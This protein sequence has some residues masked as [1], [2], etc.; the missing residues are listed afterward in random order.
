MTLSAEPLRGHD[1]IAAA[2]TETVGAAKVV[3][4]HTHLFAPAFGPL[5]LWGIDELLNY[6]YLIAELFRVAPIRYG[7]WWEMPREEQADMIWSELFVKRPPI[8]EATQ[9]VVRVMTAFGLDATAPDLREARAFF[10]A[11]DAAAHAERVLD[12]AG[13]DWLVMTNDPFDGEEAALWRAGVTGT[14]RYRAALRLDRMLNAW[15]EACELLQAGGYAVTEDVTGDTF[16]EGRR[17]LDDWI[18][19]MKPLYMAVSLPSDFVFP[20]DSARTRLLRGVVL[21]TCLEH[22]LPL[23][24]MIGVRRQVNPNMRLAGDAVGRADITSV[25]HIAFEYPQVRYLITM[26][27]R[28]NQHEL[29]VSA[30]KFRNL[31]PFGCWWFL[32]NPSIVREITQERLE[33]LGATFIAQHSDARVLDQLLYKWPVSRTIIARALTETYV[34]LADAGRPVTGAD[35][36]SDVDRLF[37]QNFCAWVGA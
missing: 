29:C 13:V 7:D 27:S 17:F 31:L 25:E 26:L 6:H 16:H 3:D 22:R 21:P 36:Q 14:S 18:E 15:P 35:I 9:G 30:R 19:R 32:N 23:G 34:A 33:M 24:L 1:S 10:A 12:M 20:D 8:S 11:Q 37:R 28:E 5:N 4:M 2:V